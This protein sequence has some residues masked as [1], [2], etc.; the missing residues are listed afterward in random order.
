M[1]RDDRVSSSF[2]DVRADGVQP[3]RLS[4]IVVSFNNEALLTRCLAALTAQADQDAVEILVVADWHRRGAAPSEHVKRKFAEVQWIE[5]P[6]G[7]TVPRMRALGMAASRGDIVALL[8]DDCVVEEGWCRAVLEAH[9]APDVAI[10]GAVEPGPYRRALD[11]AVY[12]CEYGRFML[13]LTLNRDLVLPGNNV[14]Y[15][16]SALSQL[17]RGCEDGFY[18]VLVHWAWQKAGLPM[19]AEPT[20]VVRNVNSW[21]L[22]DVTNSPYHHGRAFAAQRFADLPAWRRTGLGLLAL[23]LPVLKVGRIVKYTVRRR[24]LVGRLVQALPFIALFT[25][26]WSVGESV[27]CVFGPGNSA[28]K[29]R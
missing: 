12:F 4:V 11:W 19:R 23:L 10:G 5:A 22:A 14:A 20:L 6:D 18:D 29:W 21:S 13:P 9:R 8:E 2:T 17:P 26:S 28:S 27:G 16:R 3:P 15:K 24:R 25:T 7:C 1:A